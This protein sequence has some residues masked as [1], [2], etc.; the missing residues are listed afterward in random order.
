MDYLPTPQFCPDFLLRSKTHLKE[1]PPSARIANKDFPLTNK[2][3]DV[4][5][6]V[7]IQGANYIAAQ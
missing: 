3:E 5:R 4:V 2:T 7:Y 1:C 6:Q